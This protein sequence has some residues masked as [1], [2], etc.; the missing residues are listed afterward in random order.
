MSKM[1]K[2]TVTS[3]TIKNEPF[4]PHTQEQV[5]FPFQPTVDYLTLS[6]VVV[7]GDGAWGFIIMILLG[8]V[9]TI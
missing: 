4:E 6:V 8:L 9:S 5:F 3:T 7:N 2:G 1:K